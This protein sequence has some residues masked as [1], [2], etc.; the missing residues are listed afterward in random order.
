MSFAALAL[1][2]AACLPLPERAGIG[3]V[4]IDKPAIREGLPLRRADWKP[5]LAQA[6]RAFRISASGVADDTQIHTH[7]WYAEFND[8]LP[9]IASMDADVIT[10]ETSR[11]DMELLR[12]LGDFQYPNEIG[13]GVYDIHSPCVPTQDE[14]VRL[15]RK[16]VAVVPR[17]NLWINPDCGLKTRGWPETRAA[18]ASVAG[19]AKVLRKELAQG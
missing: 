2:G 17:E 19:A 16:A 18:L 3:T 4:Q 9:E 8:I 13:P 15:L 10:I 11:S 14:I 12:G 5:Y 6:T 1:A 7:I